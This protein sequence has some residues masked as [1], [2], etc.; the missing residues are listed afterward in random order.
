LLLNR[1]YD[2]NLLLQP[3][4]ASPATELRIDEYGVKPEY[5]DWL[6]VQLKL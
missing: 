4:P 1:N 3:E 5:Y 2:L 6:N